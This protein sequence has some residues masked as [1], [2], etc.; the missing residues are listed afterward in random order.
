L[1]ANPILLQ[2]HTGEYRENQAHKPCCAG[3]DG[4]DIAIFVGCVTQT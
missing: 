1:I 3:R 2:V 4:G